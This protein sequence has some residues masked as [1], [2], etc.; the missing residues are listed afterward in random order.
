MKNFFLNIFFL[1]L[2][3]IESHG[4]IIDDFNSNTLTNRYSQPAYSLLAAN[5][6][7]NITATNA[8]NFQVFNK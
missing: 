2:L 7:L 6:E 5:Q 1:I 8:F 4:Q 3:S